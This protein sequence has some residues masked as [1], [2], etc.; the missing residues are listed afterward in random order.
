MSTGNPAETRRRPKQ[1]RAR[2]T[3]ASI[4]EA[5]EI[6]AREG[7]FMNL[8]TSRI[9]ARAGISV[10]SL[11]QYFA[12]LQSILLSLYEKHSMEVAYKMKSAMVTALDQPPE[13]ALLEVMWVILRLHERHHMILHRMADEVPQLNLA[14]HPTSLKNLIHGSVSAY[15]KHQQ[16][17]ASTAEL[18]RKARIL[19]SIVFG[20]IKDYLDD[21]GNISKA[22]L[23]KDLNA[24]CVHY[25]RT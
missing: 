24:I 22:A 19:E 20:C 7:G 25:I 21:P 8:E 2:L 23:V 18:N 13:Q 16:L 12:N 14:H 15:L 6:L 5:T 17:A 9:A 10:G 3:V 4:L 11:Y 1:E